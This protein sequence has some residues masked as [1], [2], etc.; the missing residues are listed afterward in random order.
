MVFFRAR[1]TTTE[2]PPVIAGWHKHHSVYLLDNGES[3]SNFTGTDAF[4]FKCSMDQ[5]CLGRING[6]DL[7]TFAPSFFPKK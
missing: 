2:F 1:L 4:E 6:W 3:A 5:Q 7:S